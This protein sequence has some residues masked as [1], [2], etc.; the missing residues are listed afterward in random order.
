MRG[1]YERTFK[2]AFASF[3]SGVIPFIFG[4]FHGDHVLNVFKRFNKVLRWS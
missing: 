2:K 3:G 1:V 4:A